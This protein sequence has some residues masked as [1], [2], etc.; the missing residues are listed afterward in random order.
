MNKKFT[1]AN[2]RTSRARPRQNLKQTT[3]PRG[4]KV[5][6]IEVAPWPHKKLDH[7]QWGDSMAD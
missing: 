1:N 6:A 5:F 3:L 4:R 2:N 7:K